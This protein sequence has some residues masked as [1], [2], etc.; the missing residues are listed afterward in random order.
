MKNKN[1][2]RYF[3]SQQE[4][5]ISKL[6]NA[7]QVSNSGAARFCA[8]DVATDDWLIE[9]KTSMSP[10]QS[11]SI[12]KDWLDKNKL[13]QQMTQKPYSCLV[14]QFEPQGTNYFVVDEHL[15]KKMFD[16]YNTKAV[17]DNVFL[18]KE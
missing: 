7:R 9:C 12:K 11:F 17:L 15:F 18:D 13:E 8:G 16:R 3:S 14:F 1:S 10:K 6:L 4:E 5:Y 2:T